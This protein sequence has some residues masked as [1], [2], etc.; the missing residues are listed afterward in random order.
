MEPE[1][2]DRDTVLYELAAWLHDSEPAVED[3]WYKVRALA[4]IA[5]CSY[6]HMRKL[7]QA[8]DKAGEGEITKWHGANY[9][10]KVVDDGKSI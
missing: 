3:G 8:K 5:G 6:E 4:S 1:S 10:R 7:C 2:I 9:F